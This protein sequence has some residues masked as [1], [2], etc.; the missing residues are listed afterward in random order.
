[1]EAQVVKRNRVPVTQIVQAVG[2]AAAETTLF[3]VRDLVAAMA[4]RVPT[5]AE[6][7]GAD[8]TTATAEMGALAAGAALELN[9]PRVVFSTA[10]QIVGRVASVGAVLARELI[11][12]RMARAVVSAGMEEVWVVVAA[13]PHWAEQFSA[14]LALS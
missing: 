3:S 8:T 7:A 14:T 6:V 11:S 2:E 9:A 5:E 12:Y 13:V 1:M 4:E 10:S